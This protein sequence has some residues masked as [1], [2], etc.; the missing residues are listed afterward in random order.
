MVL[1]GMNRLFLSILSLSL[2]AALVGMLILLIRP[3][4]GRYFSRKWNYYIW[5]LVIIRLLLPIH[6]T[7]ALPGGLTFH[8]H[9]TGWK[10][11]GETALQ[12]AESETGEAS[13]EAAGKLM[14]EVSEGAAG[15]PMENASE[16]AAGKPALEASEETV[17]EMAEGNT[18]GTGYREPAAVRILFLTAEIV[19]ILGAVTA[20]CLKLWNY[21][22]Y[23]AFIKKDARPVMDSCIMVPAQSMAARLHM[24]K[25]P[26]IYESASVS[27]PVTVGLWKPVI[28]LPEAGPHMQNSFM[29]YQM[30]LHHELVH[31]ARRDLWYKW[32]Y[33]ILLCIHWFNPLLYLIERKMNMDCELSC[34]EAI[35]A[36]LTEEGRKA[37]GNV[38]LD[39][40]EKNV[41]AMKSAF[42]TT[43]VTGES[44]L[45]KR[46]TGILRYKRT[47]VLRLLLSLCVMV[48]TLFLTAC[49]GVYLIQDDSWEDAFD[50]ESAFWP[51]DSAD[52]ESGGFWGSFMEI[53]RINK[54]GEAYQVYDDLTLLSGNDL[55]DKWQAYN[56]KG[57]GNKVT[58]SGFTLNGSYSLR[59]AYVAEDMDIEVTSF[60]D[61]K[62]GK[63]KLV[64]IAPDG[65]VSTL[66]DTGAKSTVTVT[67]PKGRNMIKIVG[68]AASLK[69]VEITFSGLEGKGFEGIYYSEEDEYAGQIRN[70]IQNGSVEKDEV[71]ESL[72]YMEDEDLSEAFAALLEQGT[73]FDKD[74]LTG[75]L[76]HSDAE[77]SGNY[78]A[79]AINNGY[80]E[81]LS[82]DTLSEVIVYLEGEAKGRLINAL[83]AED[84]FEGLMECR[85][86]LDEK[87]LEE[88]LLAYIDAGGKLSYA[89]FDDIEVY[90]S[91]STIEK[92]DER[93]A[94]PSE[95]G[96]SE[97]G[98]PE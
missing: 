75:I 33:Q 48:G 25:L 14:E 98:A 40:A 31:V 10:T 69:N 57:G 37:Y 58:I 41:S 55:N 18:E 20:L 91:R 62:E 12:A 35:L 70:T 39:I 92:M 89:Q 73:V 26:P 82:V 23:I 59:I 52:E 51:F 76:I 11:A 7:A 32:L 38:L 83:P 13:E 8:L 97:A 81:P 42:T 96:M 66:N 71:M 9:S 68:Q 45:K 17:G 6:F 24:R 49:G 86:F 87:E 3:L 15:K 27:G 1:Y 19:W 4:T 22:C 94:V 54:D 44:E 90:L 63:F 61:L 36:E 88:C 77:R 21:H 56:Y 30:I 65:T 64:H 29:Q 34:D 80:I 67:M 84:F 5:F 72:Y 53:G 74:E 93:M 95:A 50:S 60:F 16:E 85:P 46:L 47:T 78:L 2:S 79:D 28:I 43:F